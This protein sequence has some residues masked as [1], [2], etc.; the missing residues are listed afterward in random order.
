MT[1]VAVVALVAGAVI[2]VLVMG[3]ILLW[4][5]RKPTTEPIRDSTQRQIW[6]ERAR[7]AR[8]DFGLA[9]IR[10]VGGKWSQSAAAIVGILSTVAIVA[11]P[12]ALADDVGGTEAVVAAALILVAGAVAAI[13]TLLAALA[14]QGTPVQAD[15]DAAAY[16]TLVRSRAEKAAAQV[17]ASRALTILALVLIVAA[18][19]VAWL[20]ALTGE[21]EKPSQAAVVV[22]RSGAMCGTLTAVKQRVALKVGGKTY[23]IR[24]NARITPVTSC[25]KQ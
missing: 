16:R 19:A 13:A 23:P 10:G 9:A 14:E 3:L 17:H 6:D 18:A 7:L 25:P 20:T 11:G 5:A 8:E 24:S 1:D 21:E 15:T 12:D 2:L 4:D 22:G